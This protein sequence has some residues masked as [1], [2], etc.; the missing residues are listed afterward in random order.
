MLPPSMNG[1]GKD[2][3]EKHLKWKN[4]Y[5]KAV[6]N[7]IISGKYPDGKTVQEGSAIVGTDGKRVEGHQ[8][9]HQDL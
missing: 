8:A 6:M 9:V 4:D 7:T 5:E 3:Y 2:L 1:P